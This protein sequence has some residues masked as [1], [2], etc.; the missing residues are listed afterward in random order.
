MTQESYKSFQYGDSFPGKTLF[1]MWQFLFDGANSLSTGRS[2]LF[3]E[4]NWVHSGSYFSG[5][6]LDSVLLT[7]NG[8]ICFSL[9]F[10]Y[11]EAQPPQHIWIL[12][13]STASPLGGQNSCSLH[14]AIPIQKFDSILR[15]LNKLMHA[16]TLSC[17]WLYI[18]MAVSHNHVA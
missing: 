5:I 16:Y 17:T 13:C 3:S 10:R 4:V 14:M 18:Y 12:P 1:L 8:S 9:Q 7:S 11:V 15:L 6:V 2:S